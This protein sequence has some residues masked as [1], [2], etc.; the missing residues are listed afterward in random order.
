M[1]LLVDAGNTRIKWR[2]V[3][4]GVLHA[5][6]ATQTVAAA[7]LEPVW[8]CFPLTRALI[9]CVADET[10]QTTL[11]RAFASIGVTPRWLTPEREKYGLVNRYEQPE[12]LGADRYAALIA[13][14]RLKL[15]DCIVVNVGTAT[16]VDMLSRNAEFLGGVIV[17][18]PDLMRASLLRGTGQVENRMRS[19]TVSLPGVGIA[20]W[21]RDTDTAVEMGIALAQAGVINALCARMPIP[22]ARPPLVIL[23]GGA[24]DKVRDWLQLELI[25][26]EDLV[27]EGLAWI[28]LDTAAC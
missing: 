6:G 21:P 23:S 7:E 14:A 10:T 4:A 8:R 15:G 22:D 18:G 20:A 5:S 27:L 26:I 16:T 3:S 28:D 12:K 19:S 25:E 1:R 17:P 13:A 2:I 24:R 11:R 9:S